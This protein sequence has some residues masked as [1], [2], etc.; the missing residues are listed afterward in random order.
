MGYQFINQYLN[1]PAPGG[2]TLIVHDSFAGTPSTTIEARSPDTV[3]NGQTWDVED[4]AT[5]DIR[6]SGGGTAATSAGSNG[7]A[8]IETS[9]ADVRIRTTRSATNALNRRGGILFRASNFSNHWRFVLLGNGTGGYTGWELRRT[10]SG[11]ITTQTSGNFG[12]AYTSG[13]QIEIL[14]QGSRIRGYVSQDGSSWTEVFDVT[15]TTHQT[16]T[17]HGIIC[18]NSASGTVWDFFQVYSGV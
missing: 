12:T 8:L 9:V 2:E 14:C 16:N 1:P 11:T 3:N 15:N 7:Y 5:E 18:T 10:S 4:T 6:I 17:K 13:A